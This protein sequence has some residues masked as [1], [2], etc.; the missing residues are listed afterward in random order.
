[1]INQKLQIIVGILLVVLY[2]TCFRSQEGFLKF[3]RSSGTKDIV[4][5][6]V[7]FTDGPVTV[8]GHLMV[9]TSKKRYMAGSSCKYGKMARVLI[10]LKVFKTYK[11]YRKGFKRIRQY[12]SIQGVEPVGYSTITGVTDDNRNVHIF[13]LTR[14]AIFMAENPKYQTFQITEND[15][16]MILTSYS[17]KVDDIIG[18]YT[19]TKPPGYVSVLTS[20]VDPS[21]LKDRETRTNESKLSQCRAKLDE[22]RARKQ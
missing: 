9:G 16:T 14:K 21:A 15:G 17:Q 4:G 8:K 7:C 19:R 10:Q 18:K 11:S 22:C 5:R 6:D 2:F 12:R 13:K 3:G 20:H 1:M